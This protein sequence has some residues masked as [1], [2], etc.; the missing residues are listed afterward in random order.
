MDQKRLLLAAALSIGVLLI[1]G[2]LFPPPPS[3]RQAPVAVDGTS[4][5]QLPDRSV[6]SPPPAPPSGARSAE[7]TGPE[8]N[9]VVEEVRASREETVVVESTTATL[10]FTNRG[11]QL[12]SFRLRDTLDRD[13]EPLE[14]VRVRDPEGPFPF[15]LADPAGGSLALN[16]SLFEIE[17]RPSR[18]GAG[19]LR[20][21]YAGSEGR[22]TKEFAF[23]DDGMFDVHVTV[24]GVG[25]WGLL[26]GPG[27]RNPS[28]DELGSQFVLRAA[29]HATPDKPEQYLTNSVDGDIRIPGTGIGWFGLEDTYFLSVLAPLEPLLETVVQ[30]VLREPSL[31]DA[32]PRYILRPPEDRISE[33]QDDMVRDLQLILVPQGDELTGTAYWGPKSY[34]TLA[35]LPF[36][37][38]ETIRFGLRIPVISAVLDPLVGILSRWMLFLL[39][40]IH[41]TIVGNYGWSIVLLTVFIKLLLMPLTHKSYVSMQKMQKLQPKIESIKQKYRGKQRDKQ[42][43]P[44]LESQRKQNEEMQA[45]FRSEG[46]N[47]AAGCLPLLLQMPVFFSLFSLLRNTVE[48][49]GSPWVFWIHDLSVQDPFYALPLVMGGAQFA[50]QRMTPMTNTNP[51]QKILLNTMPIWLTVI[52]FGFPSGLVLYWLTNSLLT[53]AQQGAYK[54]LK[55]AGLFGGEATPD[56]GKSAGKSKERAERGKKK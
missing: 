23:R 2:V 22:A 18:S 44:N 46:V 43:R 41:D 31:G 47:P 7:T 8:A 45:L 49:W 48:L 28:E 51:G 36:D 5:S 30:P 37:L 4:P 25:P 3:T 20:F 21:R 1:W 26:Q 52:S 55:Q 34:R 15:A 9:P 56:D 54:K 27:V 14:M 24:G 42:G 32:P 17:Q 16:S 19:V 6:V 12:L 40:W 35:A 13:G 50:Q 38:E 33:A 29:S 10:L 53:M 39:L 11:A